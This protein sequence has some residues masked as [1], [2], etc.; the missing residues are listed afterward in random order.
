MVSSK[1]H[2]VGEISQWLRVRVQEEI[3][4]H[5]LD[6]SVISADQNT[7]AVIIDGDKSKIKRLHTDMSQVLPDTTY[8]TELE[9]SL[10]KPV[11]GAR[12]K[13]PSTPAFG[14]TGDYILQYLK[15]LD[16]RTVRIEQA[17]ARMEALLADGRVAFAQE[18]DDDEPPEDD[19]PDV[20]EE[21][22]SG[23]VAMFG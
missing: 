14:Q 20:T 2:I 10:Q 3:Y 18:E 9:F 13:E 17:V 16:K 6:G 7:L 1:F 15:E 11:R 4:A 19:V 23:F 22:A 21:A 8:L 5:G 12:I